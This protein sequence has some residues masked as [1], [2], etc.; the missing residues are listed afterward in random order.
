MSNRTKGHYG[1][2]ETPY[3]P[4]PKKAPKFCQSFH[5]MDDRPTNGCAG[6]IFVIIF[7]LLGFAA[8]I[9]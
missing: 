7:S 9:S 6:I 1:P 5:D 2:F 8:E 3:G 4:K